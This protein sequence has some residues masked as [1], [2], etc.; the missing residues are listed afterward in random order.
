MLP[1]CSFEPKF[2]TPYQNFV[3]PLKKRGMVF[4]PHV[5]VV[6]YTSLCVQ[7]L[8]HTV[9][10]LSQIS[11]HF[12]DSR[13]LAVHTNTYMLHDQLFLIDST[14]FFSK[15]QSQDQNSTLSQN[16]LLI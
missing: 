2:M 9:L 7:C 8:L 10:R 15:M 12:D 3:L 13:N 4:M 5:C 6:P 16:I 14:L 1:I 11:Y